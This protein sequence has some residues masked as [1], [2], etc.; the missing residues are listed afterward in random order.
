MQS[1]SLNGSTFDPSSL[2]DSEYEDNLRTRLVPVPE[3]VYQAHIKGVPAV[4]SGVKDG[5]RWCT[6][7]FLFVLD[8]EQVKK[9]TQ[10]QEPTVRYSMFLDMDPSSTRL[11]T[12]TDNPNANI[13]LGRLK[14]ACGIKPGRKWSLR[15]FDGLSCWV[16]VKQRTDPDDIETIYSDI[17][18]VSKERPSTR[19]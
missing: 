14:E 18:A 16:R 2:L 4:R 19:A 10:L 8:D 11:L 13:K 15:H 6:A 12:E 7:D 3:G 1:Q 5:N 9:D 17:V